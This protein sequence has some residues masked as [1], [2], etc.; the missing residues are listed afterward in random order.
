MSAKPR[1]KDRARDQTTMT[2]SLPDTLKKRI[3]DAATAESRKA[4]NWLVKTLTDLLDQQEEKAPV[5]VRG[6]RAGRKKG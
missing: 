2:V 5:A 1:N 6:S 3:I 4:S